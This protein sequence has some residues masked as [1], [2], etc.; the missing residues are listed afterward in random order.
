M[1]LVVGEF[2]QLLLKLH[3]QL[4]QLAPPQR[5]HCSISMPNMRLNRRAH[6]MATCLDVGRS[7]AIARMR[8]KNPRPAGVI[9]A[10]NA[11]CGA[12]TP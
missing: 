7:G 8:A 2:L 3:F 6:V 1:L 5:T 10:R 11:A 9:A 12:K 4:R